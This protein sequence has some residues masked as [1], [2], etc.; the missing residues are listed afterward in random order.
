MK[1]WFPKRHNWYRLTADWAIPPTVRHHHDNMQTLTGRTWSQHW[2]DFDEKKV[3]ISSQVQDFS[4]YV[5][6]DLPPR[7][8]PVLVKGTVFELER[9]YGDTERA[10]LRILASPE[11]RLNPRKH[12]GKMAGAG[13]LYMSFDDFLTFPEVEDV[14]H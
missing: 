6:F 12:G 11:P 10:T 5:V 2:T 3:P 9:L 7:A 13:R 8:V 14:P 4:D 1:I